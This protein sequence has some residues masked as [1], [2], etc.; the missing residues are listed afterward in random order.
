MKTIPRPVSAQEF[1]Q[2]FQGV[3]NWGCWGPEDESA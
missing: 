3:C 2:L 1:E